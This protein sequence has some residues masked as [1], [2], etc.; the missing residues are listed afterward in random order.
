MKVRVKDWVWR[1]NICQRNKHNQQLLS[2][3]LQPL[4]IPTQIWVEISMDFV[5]GLPKSK[6]KSIILVV[7]DRLT[8]DCHFS[9][10]AHS[11]MAGTV[12]QLLFEKIFHLHG[13]PQS[14]VYD[15]DPTFTSQFWTELFRLQG[16]R[17]NFSS[18]NHPQTDGQTEVV[19]RKLEMYLR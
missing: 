8:E 4:P 13:M 9:P 1:C 10:L 15:R 5:E 7:V 2:G 11:Y 12:A 17:F 16:I 18:A 3:L 6:G 14:I 19:N